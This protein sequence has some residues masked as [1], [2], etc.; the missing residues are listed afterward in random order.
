MLAYCEQYAIPFVVDETNRDHRGGLRSVMR[1]ALH[2]VMVKES[3]SRYRSWQEVYDKFGQ[4]QCVV[5]DIAKLQRC[6]CSQ[7]WPVDDLYL[8]HSSR[9]T[10]D[11][12]WITADVLLCLVQQLPV[13]VTMTS[14]TLDE[15]LS[16]IGH[17]DAGYM[18]IGRVMRVLT[19]GQLSIFLI[20]EQ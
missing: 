19:H 12:S 15:L 14:A 1:H 17:S 8:V 20:S 4:Y 3:D 16:W 5:R 7:Y 10:T 11:L 2:A 13:H 9:A 18:Q 6:R